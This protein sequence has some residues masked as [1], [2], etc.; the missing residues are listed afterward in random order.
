MK[1]REFIA[2]IGGAAAAL[3]LAADAQQAGMPVIGFLNSGSLEG[4]AYVRAAVR[5]GLSEAGYVENQN[6]M[7]EYRFAE[8]Q[9]ERLPQLAADLVRRGVSVIIAGPRTEAAAKSATAAIPIVFMSGTD[10]IRAGLVTSLN[11]PTENVTGVTILTHDLETKRIGLLRELVPNFQ[12]MAILEETNHPEASFRR[13]QVQMAAGNFG[14]PIRVAS[15][16]NERDFDAVFAS[17]KREGVGA[18]LV[19]ASIYFAN[20]RD[21]LVAAAADHKIPAMY[22]LRQFAQSGGLMSYGANIPEAYRQVGLYVA[23]IL[24]GVKPADLP[25]QQPT[26]FELVINLKTAKTLGLDVPPTLLARADEVI[27]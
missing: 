27:E 14:I 23:K 17:L 9:F 5:K 18:L 21:R 8:G 7:I 24:K 25:V 15:T 4:A 19:G 10:P 1:R 22:E 11:R 13:Q 2:L 6:I 3:P 16:A 26:Q 20:M 12:V